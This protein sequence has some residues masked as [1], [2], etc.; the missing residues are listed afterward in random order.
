MTKPRRVS[1]VNH[2]LYRATEHA[3]Q[4]SELPQR[5]APALSLLLALSALGCGGAES[6]PPSS[7]PS[8]LGELRSALEDAAASRCSMADLVSAECAGSWQYQRWAACNVSEAGPVT[9]ATC[10]TE[11]TCR[12]WN[13]CSDW[14]LGTAA[15]ATQEAR[16]THLGRCKDSRD[17]F[18]GCEKVEDQIQ[19]ALEALRATVPEP[20]RALVKE[21]S[22]TSERL[23]AEKVSCSG[24]E[25]LWEDPRYDVTEEC[26]VTLEY[27][28][29]AAGQSPVCGCAGYEC[30][31]PACGPAPTLFSSQSGLSLDALQA[32]DPLAADTPA[33][34]CSTCDP[35]PVDSP[36]SAQAKLQCLNARRASVSPE[37]QPQLDARTRVLL[38]LAGD[39]LSA[40]DRSKAWEAFAAERRAGGLRCEPPSEAAPVSVEA[41]PDQDFE[42][43]P[44]RSVQLLERD[45]AV[46]E[47]L[48]GV[49]TGAVPASV[50]WVLAERCI[51]LLERVTEA[52][53]FAGLD[54]ACVDEAFS[55]RTRDTVELVV[56][57]SLEALVQ[58][59]S[60]G[61]PD[62]ASPAGYPELVRTLVL[63]DRWFAAHRES[64]LSDAQ[65]GVEAEAEADQTLSELLE[66]FWSAA[67]RARRVTLDLE[68]LLAT[69]GAAEADIDAAIDRAAA[70]AERLA[71]DV[72]GAAHRAAGTSV[73]ALL[74][75]AVEVLPAFTL[76]ASSTNGDVLLRLTGDALTGLARALE[77]A[78]PFHDLAC[79]LGG[80]GPRALGAAFTDTPL[81]AFW[82]ALAQLDRDAQ[83][84][85]LP[86]VFGR[87][88][89]TPWREALLAIANNRAALRAAIAAATSEPHEV[90]LIDADPRRLKPA[91]TRLAALGRAGSERARSYAAT[92]F[93]ALPGARRIHAN[94]S[95]AG[96]A[97]TLAA[98]DAA[99]AGFAA[100]AALFQAERRA[101]AAEA[102][103]RDAAE[104]AV[105]AVR[106]RLQQLDVTLRRLN[107][108]AVGLS[109]SLQALEARVGETT[110]RAATL[111]EVLDGG[112][113]TRTGDTRRFVVHGHDG[114]PASRAAGAPVPIE[115]FAARDIELGVNGTPRIEA[116]A[117]QLVMVEAAGEYSPLCALSRHDAEQ[118]RAHVAS[119]V[120]L[121]EP[122]SSPSTRLS[123]APT[124]G[125]TIG[126]EGFQL[127]RSA[128]R[129][130]VEQRDRDAKDNGFFK[131]L[132]GVVD[133]FLPPVGSI[134][135]GF[136]DASDPVESSSS[137]SRLESVSQHGGLRLPGTPFPDL[138]A[139]ALL[140]VELPRGATDSSQIRDAHLV[141][142]G[143]TS[144]VVPAD[145]DLY[146]VVNDHW[147]A[148][149]AQCQALSPASDP[150]GVTVSVR[151]AAP[152]TDVAERSIEALQEVVSGLRAVRD[153][154]LRQGRIVGS[155]LA[156][157][158][159]E[160]ELDFQVRAGLELVALP[161]V[162]RDVIEAHLGRELAAAELAVARQA[163][164][165]AAADVALE[166]EPLLRELR[167]LQSGAQGAGL[168]PLWQLRDL[169]ELRDEAQERGLLQS[170]G[171]LVSRVSETLLPILELW[172]P[173]VLDAVRSN[174]VFQRDARQLA[175]VVPEL[176]PLTL[177]DEVE[178]L[179]ALL[180]S[181]YASDPLAHLPDP[182]EQPIVGVSFARPPEWGPACDGCTSA[183]SGFPRASEASAFAVWNAI[184]AALLSEQSLPRIDC[185]SDA[186]CLSVPGTRC[187]L[188]RASPICVRAST[189]AELQ[190][191]PSDIYRRSGGQATLSCFLATPVIQQ[192]ALVFADEARDRDALLRQLSLSGRQLEP[193][194]RPSQRFVTEAGLLDYT[195]T[196]A[197]SLSSGI[198][199]LYS[200]P[201]SAFE[202]FSTLANSRSLRGRNP[203]GLSAFSTLS[204]D[205]SPLASMSHPNGNGIGESEGGRVS[206]LV[207]VMRLDARAFASTPAG[208]ELEGIVST[209]APAYRER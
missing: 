114:S 91:A 31:S 133:K 129:A 143:V 34:E 42:V 135:K 61:Q 194:A 203:V 28:T 178:R 79:R 202:S 123:L 193:R 54:N 172:H 41:N 68:A 171:A 134:A 112:A 75:G 98:L 195:M 97:A 3:A 4:R 175:G 186:E 125:T 127:V 87:L 170:A 145:A 89:A 29:P 206:E 32:L 78:E 45:L 17:C 1:S 136:L 174:A 9:A 19:T 181:A 62:L 39:Q 120:A 36:A 147:V 122:A 55:A 121:V 25:C 82:S 48:A 10:L 66:A 173:N 110:S 149:D 157:A 207:L 115:G 20:Q 191:E 77:R 165:R 67:Q 118:P 88:P 130:S 116:D 24:L 53:T 6:A 38:L 166:A 137:S 183:P 99:S 188:T 182:L 58:R 92:G 152:N 47:Q 189:Q 126:P 176:D 46:C 18:D 51:G 84:E 111:E 167:R 30:T 139:G 197:T 117:R 16:F 150:N 204:V 199:L 33:P 26:R 201:E 103:Q 7:A 100:E 69:S 21:V 94:V 85:T 138:P 200:R 72:L 73:P 76:Q 124:P 141:Q 196:D 209:C 128:S 159:A 119:L 192:W 144:F 151:L 95:A 158:R 11:P 162:L 184:E 109:T 180:R 208:H 35:L 90:A 49:S 154:Y 148:E 81:A 14:T 8:R 83:S 140:L 205:F 96:R 13:T 179:I 74:S 185:D 153:D 37:A 168:G 161:P 60:L 52:R 22:R 156:Q 56:R 12:V 102:A 70:R 187:D 105:E 44:A 155:Q 177:T 59:Q 5:S 146:F 65:D 164:E 63:V 40:A 15:P 113:F 101:A 57:G 108:D 169:G 104:R 107:A 142:R 64:L 198:S 131:T 80:C 27:P 2:N 190:I 43:C 93:L 163:L 71:R 86:L 23:S 160:A 132:L 50:A 106:G